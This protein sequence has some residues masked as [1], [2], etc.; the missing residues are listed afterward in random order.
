MSYLFSRLLLIGVITGIPAC[1]IVKDFKDNLKAYDVKPESNYPY[2]NS[3]SDFRVAWDIV[4]TSNETVFNGYI[5]NIRN[6]QASDIYL[7]I[8][9]L[10]PEGRQLSKGGTQSPQ[11]LYTNDSFAFSIKLNDIKISDGDVL[12]F[13]IN[14][15]TNS[16]AWGGGAG[17]SSFEVDATTGIAIKK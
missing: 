5:K 1:T 16:G 14:Y 7:D 3:S 8:E 10:S 6:I 13:F 9:V 2:I 17:K 15:R 11:T 12:K 4:Q